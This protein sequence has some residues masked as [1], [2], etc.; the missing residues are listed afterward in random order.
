MKKILGHPRVELTG[1]DVTES[2]FHLRIGCECVFQEQIRESVQERF[3]LRL[4][5]V[6]SPAPDGLYKLC[7]A[8]RLPLFPFPLLRVRLPCRM[9]SSFSELSVLSRVRFGATTWPRV[10]TRTGDV[11]EDESTA[12]RADPDLVPRR[13]AKFTRFRRLYEQRGKTVH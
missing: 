13:L 11:G 12:R 5:S 9:R 3:V 6:R 4:L 2:N 1:R 10:T 8:G 7:S